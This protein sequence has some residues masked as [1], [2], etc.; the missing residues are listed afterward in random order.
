MKKEI[1]FY[2]VKTAFS[3]KGFNIVEI[4]GTTVSN[5]FDIFNVFKKQL[6]FPT[7]FGENWDAF[8]DCLTDLSWLKNKKTVIFIVNSNKLKDNELFP[9]FISSL[10]DAKNYWAKLKIPFNVEIS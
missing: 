1:D 5:K 10:N 6:H 2:E 8:Y 9:I 4:D 3:K 7:Y